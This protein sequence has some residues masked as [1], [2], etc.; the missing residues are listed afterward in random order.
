[1]EI[2]Q[3]RVQ[4]DFVVTT[5]ADRAFNHSDLPQ[6][7]RERLKLRVRDRAAQL[8]DDWAKAARDYQEN[9]VRFQYNEYEAGGAKPL[10]HDYLSA[11][12][13]NLP[14]TNWRMKFRAN[15]SLRDVEQ[16]VK[17]VVR[18]LENMELDEETV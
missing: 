15:R 12:V 8:I 7:D 6:E 10:L 3:R 4:L 18:T 5:L 9:G 16:E 17:I 2:L 13:K 11:E 14:P 1:M